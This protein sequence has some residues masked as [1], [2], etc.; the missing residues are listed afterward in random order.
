MKK[1]YDYLNPY[2]N[3]PFILNQ[4]HVYLLYIFTRNDLALKVINFISSFKL[5]HAASTQVESRSCYI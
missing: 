1:Q 4:I 5:R 2:K 3:V